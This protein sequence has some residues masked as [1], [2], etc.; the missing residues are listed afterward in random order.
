VTLDWMMAEAEAEELRFV[1]WMRDEVAA[2]A[3]PQGE[4]YD[5]RAGIAGYYRYGPRN[6]ADLCDDKEHGVHVPVV[7]VHPSAFNRIIARERDYAPV[8][9]GGAFSVSGAQ[10][11][12][13]EAEAMENAAD[14]VWW[15]RFVYFTTLEVTAFLSL[16]FLVLIFKW[17]KCILDFT[18]HWL[19]KG[20]SVIT[21]LLGETITQWI[22]DAW[23]LLLDHVGKLLPSWAGP[24]IP[25]FRDYP[26]SGIVALILLAL[27]FFWWADA[28]QRRIKV[29]SE[30]AWAGHKG[31]V[32]SAKP[33]TSWLNPVGRAIRPVT[34]FLY[35]TVWR[36]ALV[37]I[38][39]I[40]LGIIAMI[41]F[42]PY[43]LPKLFRRRPWMA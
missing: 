22:S 6:V 29:F 12:Q 1:D 20:W 39:G 13:A 8:S 14:I 7:R 37:F 24:A 17:P 26:L 33:K 43:W 34:G 41:L 21:S 40:G 16:F 27:L 3:N 2:R 18:E 15:R 35:R 23:S 5:S 19:Q 11:T 42:V 25:S 4:Q 31:L 38:L 30:W 36:R 32:A 10:K 9:L 28:L